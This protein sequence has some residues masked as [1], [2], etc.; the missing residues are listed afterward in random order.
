MLPSDTQKEIPG[1]ERLQ[2][3][4]SECFAH[5]KFST[6]HEKFFSA[7]QGVTRKTEFELAQLDE[8]GKKETKSQTRNVTIFV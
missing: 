3:R 8:V 1:Q 6:W 7:P 4:L 2:S 5:A